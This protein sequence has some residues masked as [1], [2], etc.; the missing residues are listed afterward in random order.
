MEFPGIITFS[1]SLVFK[2]EKPSPQKYCLLGHVIA[3]E[4]A[5]MWFGNYVTMKWWDGLWLN[6]SFADFTSYLCKSKI[7]PKMK[8]PTVDAWTA[9]LVR[10]EKGYV[11]DQRETTH[12][13]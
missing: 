9:F 2:D 3:H 7:H 6:E 11:D 8:F 5:H 13:I 4:L 1:D 10:V 12:P